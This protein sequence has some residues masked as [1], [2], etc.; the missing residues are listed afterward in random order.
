MRLC[1]RPSLRLRWRRFKESFR[2]VATDRRLSSE[3]LHAALLMF[4]SHVRSAR[5]AC[6]T[7]WL[8]A[9]ESELARAE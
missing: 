8:E 3:S 2:S 9:F 4:W 7:I 5:L 1:T 6:T